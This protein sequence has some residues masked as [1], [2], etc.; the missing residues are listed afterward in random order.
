VLTGT[1]SAH[2]H[3]HT[4]T[5]TQTDRQC[6]Q[7]HTVLTGT[8]SAYRH[9]QY[10][11]ALAVLTGSQAHRLA[12]TQAHAVLTRNSYRQAPRNSHQ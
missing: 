11:Q 1:H 5:H 6:S 3:T 10:S 8:H 4:H 7:A 12:C 9:T 2:K